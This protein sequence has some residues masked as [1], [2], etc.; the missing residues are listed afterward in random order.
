MG[1]KPYKL[2]TIRTM[3]RFIVLFGVMLI[4]FGVR[5]YDRGLYRFADGGRL[6][7]FCDSGA[8]Y[9]PCLF[10]PNGETRYRIDLCADF[11]VEDLIRDA[12]ARVVKEYYIAGGRMIYA[13]SPLISNF[14][15]LHNRRVN[16]MIFI[17]E[18]RV[19]VGV[20]M[21]FGSF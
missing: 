8:E 3:R 10:L 19:S 20:P 15:M 4:L 9:T 6:T 21:L 18:R 13:F 12:G 1:I 2:A 7:V 16:M 17:G 5:L 11:D 14:V